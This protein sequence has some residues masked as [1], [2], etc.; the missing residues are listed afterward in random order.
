MQPHEAEEAISEGPTP[1]A[2]RFASLGPAS[3]KAQLLEEFQTN[4][5][6]VAE[7][8]ELVLNEV[9]DVVS[10]EHTKAGKAVIESLDK[11]FPHKPTPKEIR[12]ARCP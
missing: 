7:E 3:E 6:E 12:A 1:L 5:Q 8:I 11:A 4:R 10:A 9:M 2:V